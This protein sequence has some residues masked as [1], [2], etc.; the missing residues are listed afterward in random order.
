MID[1][2]YHPDHYASGRVYEP[3]DVINDWGLGFNLGDVVKYIA[4][5]G[6]KPGSDTL[7]DLRK[8]KFYLDYH[9][10][11]LEERADEADLAAE[12][13]KSARRAEVAT[14][15]RQHVKRTRA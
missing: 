9:I 13:A 8:A 6:R 5:A 1:E 4:R 14:S 3:I 15:A 12:N 2:I 11:M 7:T 10:A